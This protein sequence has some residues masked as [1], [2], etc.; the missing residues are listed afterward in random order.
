[1]DIRMIPA[2]R[3]VEPAWA[4]KVRSLVICFSSVSPAR[5]APVRHS[6]DRTG[7]KMLPLRVS[8]R[9]RAGILKNRLVAAFIRIEEFQ[10]CHTHR[11]HVV[12][13]GRGPV[14]AQSA[15]EPAPRVVRK[16][17]IGTIDVR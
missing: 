11:V 9:I 3:A 5:N 10:G 13:N 12:L 7:Y 15:S 8:L 17:K 2:V 6:E 4:D 1:M 14:R 16:V